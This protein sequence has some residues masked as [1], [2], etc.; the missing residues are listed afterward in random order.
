[1]DFFINNWESIIA[2][3]N[4]I[5]VLFLQAKKQPKSKS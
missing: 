3:L 1:M 4:S 2:I 5:G